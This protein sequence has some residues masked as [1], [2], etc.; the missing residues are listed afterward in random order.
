MVRDKL[1]AAADVAVILVAAVGIF[2]LLR[3]QFLTPERPDLLKPGHSLGQ[4][5]RLDLRGH[6]K[7]LLLVLRKGCGYCDGSTPFYRELT[8]LARPHGGTVRLVA[9]FEDKVEDARTFLQDEGVS[10]DV[11]AEFPLSN[12]KIGVTPTL[13]LVDDQARVIKVWEGL[14]S[15]KAED[16]VKAAI[17]NQAPT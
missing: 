2:V 17:T 10:V 13:I 6:K 12:L 3:T 11:V 1:G 14:L 9:V 7:N 8:E 4:V 5:D 15:R 16:E